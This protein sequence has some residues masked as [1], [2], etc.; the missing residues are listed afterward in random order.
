[1][2]LSTCSIGLSHLCLLLKWGTIVKYVGTSGGAS[3]HLLCV[4]P[5]QAGLKREAA[6]ASGGAL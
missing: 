5:P 4:R 2:V 1:M 3:E 6:G